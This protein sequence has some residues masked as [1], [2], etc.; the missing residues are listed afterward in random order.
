[1]TQQACEPLLLPGKA[2]RALLALKFLGP[3]AGLGCLRA[4]DLGWES[5]PALTAVHSPVTTL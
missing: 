3:G 1:M 2:P 5:S 4:W